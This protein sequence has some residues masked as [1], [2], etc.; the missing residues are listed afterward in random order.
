MLGE[1]RPLGEERSFLN[2]IGLLLSR[3]DFSI[4]V[5]ELPVERRYSESSPRLNKIDVPIRSVT[6]TAGF[7]FYRSSDD[8]EMKRVMV[9][10]RRTCVI[11]RDSK[12]TKSWQKRISHAGLEHQGGEGNSRDN[13]RFKDAAQESRV[14]KVGG[15]RYYARKWFNAC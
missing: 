12:V 14:A 11:A 2:V 8:V 7:S 13:A 5:G 15:R 10:A 6:T 4:D 1:A 3:F 9:M